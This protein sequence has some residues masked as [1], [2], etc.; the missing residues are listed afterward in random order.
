MAMSLRTAA[1]TKTQLSS[2]E[3]VFGRKMDV[4]DPNFKENLPHFNEGRDYFNWLTHRLAEK[5]KAVKENEIEGK[6]EDA[7][8]TRL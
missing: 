8:I 3:V 2:F 4:R 5:H 7:A 1:H 6:E